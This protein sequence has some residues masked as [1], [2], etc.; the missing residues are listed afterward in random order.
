M[1]QKAKKKS[2]QIIM[3]AMNKIKHDDFI[4]E[5]FETRKFFN[6]HKVISTMEKS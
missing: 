5:F 1:N 2:R 3:M 6:C 4:I